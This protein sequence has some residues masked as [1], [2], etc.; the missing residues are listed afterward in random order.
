MRVSLRPDDLNAGVIALRISGAVESPWPTLED[1]LAR[2]EARWRAWFSR[3]PAVPA[4]AWAMALH[5][6]WIM[7]ANQFLPGSDPRRAGVAPSKIG[8]VG[9]WNWDACFHALGLRHGDPEA[10]KDQLRIL[11]AH[12]LPDGMLPDVVHDEG[13][14]ASTADLPPAEQGYGL[15]AGW[16]PAVAVPLTKPPLLAWAAHA[17]AHANTAPV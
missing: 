10:A 9:I 2:A 5:A 1:V 17:M 15:P 12:Q 11:L 3:I 4:Q 13:V 16:D 6:W 8:Y 14:L 7:A